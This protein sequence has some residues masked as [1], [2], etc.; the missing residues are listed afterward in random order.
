[1][2]LG[3]TL[4]I[5]VGEKRVGLAMAHSDVRVPIVLPTLLNEGDMIWDKLRNVIDEND[6]EQIVI[7][8]P[9]GL[10]GQE[11]D[12]TKIVREF[13]KTASEKLGLPIEMQDEALTSVNAEKILSSSGKSF[14]KSD[15][16]GLAAS[17]ILADYL[18]NGKVTL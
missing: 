7:G 8:L 11:T 14:N 12:Q 6:I 1:M 2:S 5:D 16:D 3:N 9:R 4:A 10:E 13:A 17:Y 18:D 15:I